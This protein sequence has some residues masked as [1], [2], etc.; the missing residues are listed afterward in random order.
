MKK[1][2]LLLWILAGSFLG[3]AVPL[4]ALPFAGRTPGNKLTASDAADNDKFAYSI[5]VSDDQIVVGSVVEDGAGTDHGAIYVYDR[6]TGIEIAKW[7]ASDAEDGDQLGH[8]VAISGKLVVAGARWEDGAGTN[9]GAAYVFDLETGT[10]LHKL[11]AS[12]SGDD[13]N[14]GYSVAIDGNFVLIGSP[15]AG[16]TDRGAAYLFDLTDPVEVSPG[17][18]SENRKLE[19]SDQIDDVKFGRSVAVEGIVGVVGANETD[20]AGIDEG[21]AYVYDLESGDEVYILSSSDAQSDDAIGWSVA[22][23]GERVLVSAH[24][25]DGAG[26]GNALR[27]AAYLFDLSDPVAADPGDPKRLHENRKFTASDTSDVSRFSWSVALSDELV[28]IG[29]V[30]ENAGGAGRGAVYV[31]DAESGAELAKL[32]AVDGQDID[33][34]G[35]CVATTGRHVYAGAPEE[36]GTGVNQGAAYAFFVPAYQPDVI[37]GAS[38][39]TGVGDNIYNASGSGQSFA[40]T[41]TSLRP[42]NAW[43][44]VQNDGDAVDTMRLTG[45]AGTRDFSITYTR[46]SL[47][48]IIN[49]TAAV[50]AGTHLEINVSPSETGRLLSAEVRPGPTLR[51]KVKKKKKKKWTI[52]RSSYATLLRCDS[53]TDPFSRDG[54]VFSVNTR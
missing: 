54:A 13:D 26:I 31:Y 8:A 9:F 29:A 53:E 50:I 36:N 25:E 38:P 46:R 40:L 41:S 14:F 37:V 48:R 2:H 12:D 30:D 15:G 49:V 34:L 33:K 18:L 44:T 51:K 1:H 3:S 22:I 35:Y 27:G 39:F 17:L 52:L 20:G 32:T 7:T 10:Q 16:A 6:H 24:G 21:A 43:W 4:V 19:P 42:V 45:G 28:V 47:G 5:A 11:I 23:R